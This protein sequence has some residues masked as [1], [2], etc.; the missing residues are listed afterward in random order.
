MILYDFD[1][2]SI[3]EIE[4][5]TSNHFIAMI[6]RVPS[7]PHLPNTWN[8]EGSLSEYDTPGKELLQPPETVSLIIDCL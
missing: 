2:A 1:F 4:A 6:K 5:A 8:G 3:L 7:L